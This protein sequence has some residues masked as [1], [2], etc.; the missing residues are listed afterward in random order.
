MENLQDE[1]LHLPGVLELRAPMAAPVPV[2][3]DSPHSGSD[4]PDDFGHCMTHQGLRRLEDAF[5]DELFDHAPQAGAMFLR[6]LFPRSYIDPNRAPDDIDVDMLDGEWPLDANPGPKT[7]SGIG[8]IFRSAQEGPVYNRKLQVSEV[9]RRL[10]AYY[11]PYHRALETALERTWQ[12]FGEVLHV[13]CHSMKSVSTGVMPEGSGVA[14]P[15][16]V[17]GDRDGSTCAPEIT[18]AVARLL[19]DAG[20]RVAVNAPYKGMELI[21]RYSDPGRGR[22]SLQIEINRSLYMDEHNVL[23]SEGFASL[24]DTLRR[25]VET[26]GNLLQI[27]GQNPAPG[28][29]SE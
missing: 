14:R 7:D 8:L 6:A 28:Y 18:A 9:R 4:Y 1:R 21:A 24:R 3:F 27:P 15:D 16:F 29:P 17:L 13:N 23:K 10:D 25:L 19:S 22:H 5:V 11:W 20:H 26:L 2:V 12:Q